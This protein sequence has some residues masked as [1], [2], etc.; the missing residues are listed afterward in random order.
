MS[1]PISR[2]GFHFGSLDKEKGEKA[3]GPEAVTVANNVRMRQED[4]WEKAPG[5]TRLEPT[6]RSESG[7]AGTW[8]GAAEYLTELQDG[9]FARE[10]TDG[11]EWVY[12]ATA[13]RWTSRGV[14]VRPFPSDDV[15][16][17]PRGVGIFTSS[18]ARPRM[19]RGTLYEWHFAVLPGSGTYF[20]TVLD[21]N[22]REV[23]VPPTVVV[24]SGILNLAPAV[25]SNGNIVVYTVEGTNL[26]HRHT[27]T[28]AAPFGVPAKT[29]YHTGSIGAANYKEIDCLSGLSATGSPNGPNALMAWG[30]NTAA[31][32]STIHWSIPT[33]SGAATVT[34]TNTAVTAPG[35]NAESMH[36]SMLVSDAA[37]GL[38]YLAV[39]TPSGA[40]ATFTLELRQVNMVTFAAAS[41][42]VFT[43]SYAE[44]V[45]AP[46]LAAAGYLAANGDRVILA[47]ILTVGVLGTAFPVS[48]TLGMSRVATA[49]FVWNGAATITVPQLGVW[50]AS[51]PVAVGS[52]WYYLVQFDDGEAYR[53]QRTYYLVK[54]SGAA[55]DVGRVASQAL[56]GLGP[57]AGHN[58]FNATSGDGSHTSIPQA[59]LVSGE[60]VVPVM[61]ATSG[62][63]SNFSISRLKFSFSEDFGPPVQFGNLAVCPG[64]IPYVV[65]PRD[66]R[67]EV[68]PLVGPHWIGHSGV[69][70]AGVVIQ[71]YYQFTDSNGDVYRS[72]PC[73]EVS[74]TTLAGVNL[75]VPYLRQSLNPNVK[76]EVVFCASL[77][78]GATA[79]IRTLIT[80]EINTS[81]LTWGPVTNPTTDDVD[82]YTAGGAL[83]NDPWPPTRCL[84]QHKQRLILGGLDESEFI[85]PTRE[86]EAGCGPSIN[87][88]SRVPW[89]RGTGNVKAIARVDGNTTAILRS[90]A[91]AVIEGQGPNGRG[92]GNF[93]AKTISDAD[94]IVRARSFVVGPAGLYYQDRSNKLQILT[95]GQSFREA[96]QGIDDLARAGYILQGG[97]H[98][99]AEGSMLFS[100][101]ASNG[102]S[103]PLL[104]FLDYRHPT[105]R[106]PAGRWSLRRSLQ[107][108]WSTKYGAAL[109]N[110]AV[111]WLEAAGHLVK[112]TVGFTD[113]GS[114]G[115]E[116]ILTKMRVSLQRLGEL[117][118][119]DYDLR[120]VLF[121]GQWMGT[122]S[123]RINVYRNGSATPVTGFPKTK[124]STPT[125]T[126]YAWEVTTPNATYCSDVEIEIEETDNGD[127][128]QG[129][130]FDGL[131]VDFQ[132]R[133]RTRKQP[134]GRIV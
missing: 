87:V 119:G 133:S 131:V 57:A 102:T 39:W 78:S 65:G 19:I 89:R 67:R 121:L 86:F 96:S 38:V 91:V 54:D 35:A 29:L 74:V 32:N 55:E 5:T 71:A 51:K 76:A 47:T 92:A 11:E 120:Q 20:F 53:A 107:S 100:F 132:S 113:V 83:G 23:I 130:T 69:A 44:P 21:I 126:P 75:S 108:Q 105:E 45:T 122:H 72:R 125:A 25:T 15:V 106:H 118:G 97:I 59:F 1:I 24:A 14:Q 73:P 12:N 98:H 116:P 2:Q 90:D 30:C 127:D 27:H 134:I 95:P 64:P 56:R 88:V 28:E 3:V 16:L 104:A 99:K 60:I 50:V 101:S 40:A 109:M 114:G 41:S 111:H 18:L 34:N 129:F 103:D 13:N 115:T 79:Q 43:T 110:G 42:T 112:E 61:K 7:G 48:N 36:G 63:V 94:G 46:L 26:I 93:V 6:L 123:W 37:N 10:V 52:D 82:V 85:Q 22:S 70:G 4:K 68:S 117:I 77:P 128:T 49:R 66:L 58:S 84:G 33:A 31:N 124:V 62:G 9:A 81:E 80:N 17:P 8:T